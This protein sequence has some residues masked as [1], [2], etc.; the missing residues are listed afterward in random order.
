[1]S[2]ITDDLH[3]PLVTMAVTVEEPLRGVDQSLP[4]AAADTREFVRFTTLHRL[5]HVCM[6]VSFITLALTGMSLKFSYTGWAVK[7][8]HILGGFETAGFI[9]RCAGL[10]MFGTFITHIVD[11]F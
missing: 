11:L 4:P 2:R 5:L 9:H 8:S 3:A 1:M 6:I 10:I 7:L